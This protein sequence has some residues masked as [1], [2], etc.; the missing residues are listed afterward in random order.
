MKFSKLRQLFLV[1]TI[2]LVV[3]TLFTGCQLVSIDYVYVATSAGTTKCGGGQIESYVVDSQSGAVRSAGAAVCA[4]GV[5]PVA[6]ALSPGNF[7]LYAAN[8]G[9]N[10]VVHF[11]LN[12][13][14]VAT[15]KDTITLAAPPV[16]LAV[17]PAGTALFVVSGKTSAT[18]TE[19]ALSSGAIGAV[20][21][22]ENLLIPGFEGD[23]LVP[24]AVTVLANGSAVFATAYDLSAYNPGGTTTSSANPGWVFGYT[25]GSGGALAPTTGNPYKAGVKPSALAADPTSRF[26]YITDF[27][28][29]QLIGYGV[30]TADVLGFLPNGPFKTGAEPISLAIDPR[31][32]FIYVA[33]ALDST[34]TAFVIDLPT[35]TPSTT[36]SSTGSSSNST[37][38]QPSAIAVDPALGRYV[39]TANFLGDSI[40]GFRLDPTAGSLKQTQATPYPTGNKPT[41]IV[42]APHGNHATQNVAP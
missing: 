1:S 34:V 23:S 10:T 16:S 32:T 3:A 18:L 35:G 2:G 12:T 11:A 37:D 24:T 26:V 5:D 15:L 41:A 39:Y 7:N 29:S 6:L 30:Q 4:G 22:Q 40:S 17:N 27:A 38:T 13:N 31:G 25:I 36:V 42:I 21:A 20:T 9:D 19:Y 33:N 28:S 14:G 8:Y